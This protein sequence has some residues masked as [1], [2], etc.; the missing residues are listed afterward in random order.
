M[1][2]T[3]S[4]LSNP[5]RLAIV[6]R[7][8]AGCQHLYSKNV[9]QAGQTHKFPS[10]KAEQQEDKLT[11][12]LN[13]LAVLADDDPIF[14]AHLTSYAFKE[15]ENRDLQLLCTFVN[16][17]S[18]ADGM[19][20][21]SGS[22]YRKPNLRRISQAAIQHRAFN[23]RMLWRLIELANLKR[24]IGRLGEGTHF[25]KH[26]VKAIKKYIRYREANPKYLEGIRKSGS[27]NKFEKLYHT[28]RIKP[29]KLAEEFFG[30]RYGKRKKKKK[31]LFDFSGLSELEIAE[32]IREDKISPM[33]AL[34]ALPDKIS[35]VVALAIL[36]QCT[37]NQAVILREQF[38]SQGLLKHQEVLELFE[39]KVK[40][41]K[42]ALD[43][44]DR[45]NSSIDEE[46]SKILKKARSDVRKE[47]AAGIGKIFLH[48]D[49]STSMGQALE[50]AK[51]FGSII[52][53]CVPNPEENFHWGTFASSGKILKTPETF[54]KDAFMAALYGVRTGGMTD[55]LACWQY[56]RSQGCNIDVFITDCGHNGNWNFKE[57]IDKTGK[58]EVVGI[59]N[60]G[61]REEFAKVKRKFEENGIPVTLINAEALTE[62]AL[63]A[64]TLKQALQGREA[65]VENI[66][67]TPLLELPKWWEAIKV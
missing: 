33:V 16:S 13:D 45:L 25:S 21:F 55:M 39:R 51:E 63:V 41:A 30:F 60:L 4:E 27:G 37:G 42:T 67:E 56:A 49:V 23:P 26:L 10:G 43:R 20:F 6:D 18:D 64:Q 35:P 53:E 2:E 65:L 40:T 15:T 52:A 14:L 11:P 47:Q 31:A 29:A 57:I 38:D 24:P 32:K 8:L 61:P 58:T 7:I 1:E 34:G 46:V 66:L 28:M 62:S 22:K 54:E 44:V 3:I 59:V 19:P 48:I 50:V 5:E 36:E 12:I 9:L 17:L